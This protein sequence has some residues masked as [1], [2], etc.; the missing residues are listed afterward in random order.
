M[1]PFDYRSGRAM[2]NDMALE[3]KID[4]LVD[5][6]DSMSTKVDGLAAQFDGMSTKVDSLSTKVDSVSGK[7]DSLS[8]K[9]DTLS[10]DVTKL[11]GEFGDLKTKVSVGF[12]ETHRLLKLSLEGLA[13]LE[14]TTVDRFD[15]MSA[16]HGKQFELLKTFG[17]HVRKRVEKLEA[18]PKA[19]RRARN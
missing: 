13:G 2:A 5:K 8:T 18:R 6:F 17:V 7:V 12:E 4:L 3:K 11:N 16:E 14:E 15:A 10:T 19:R 9:V 1:L